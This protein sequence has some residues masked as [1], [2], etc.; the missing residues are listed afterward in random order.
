MGFME[1]Y[2]ENRH[3]KQGWSEVSKTSPC[4]K[5][6]GTG[7]CSTNEKANRGIC[8]K[9]ISDSSKS[10]KNGALYTVFSLRQIVLPD[11]SKEVGPLDERHAVYSSLLKNL[12]LAPEHRAQLRLRKLSDEW[13]DEAEYRTLPI[14]GRATIAKKLID[15]HGWDACFRTPGLVKKSGVHGEYPSTSGAAGLLIPCR[16]FAG[17]I[18]SICIRRNGAEEPRYL[19]M[20]SSSNNGVG[21]ALI[22]HIPRG[23]RKGIDYVRV[24]EGVLKADVTSFLSGFPTI[25]LPG[26]GNWNTAIWTLKELGATKVLFSPDADFRNKKQVADNCFNFIQMLI[27]NHFKV[28]LEYWGQDE[29]G[30]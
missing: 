3:D 27:A 6:G 29:Q 5:C 1:N 8:R 15:I 13:I 25:G 4:L 19:W 30:H 18:H 2:S 23:I 10:D 9:S 26:I 7:W 24:T 17:K 12:P 21:A 11:L 20:S 22:T 14:K 28:E 16:T